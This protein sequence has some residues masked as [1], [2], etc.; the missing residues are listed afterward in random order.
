[1]LSPVP[2]VPELLPHTPLQP[3][4]DVYLLPFR[5]DS[6]GSESAFLSS[7]S[8]WGLVSRGKGLQKSVWKPPSPVS[9]GHGPG[10]VSAWPHVRLASLQRIQRT[11]V[12]PGESGGLELQLLLPP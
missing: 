7:L 12:P 8:M 1:M 3:G 4:D 6:S 11:W 2:W 9:N 5:K 10:S